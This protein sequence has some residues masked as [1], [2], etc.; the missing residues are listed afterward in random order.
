LKNELIVGVGAFKNH[1]SNVRY[2]GSAFSFTNNGKF[3][4]F[5]CFMCNQTDELA[6]SIL[7]SFTFLLKLNGLFWLKKKI[8]K[9]VNI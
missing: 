4:K 8:K 2:I 9:A 1:L 7:Q 6:G 5:E 3:N